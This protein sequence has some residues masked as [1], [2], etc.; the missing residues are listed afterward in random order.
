MRRH[1]VHCE[2]RPIIGWNGLQG[3]A[4][5]L[6]CM[7]AVFAVGL[8]TPGVAVALVH[9]GRIVFQ[10][11]ETRPASACRLLRLT[12]PARMTGKW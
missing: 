3:A 6:V 1:H 8:V 5:K 11:R 10:N 7:I 2:H 4:R 12:R 9:S